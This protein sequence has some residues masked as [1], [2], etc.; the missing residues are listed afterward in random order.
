MPIKAV[1]FDLDGTLLPMDQEAFVDTYFKE[2][3]AHMVPYGYDPKELVQTVWRGTVAMIQNDGS[4]TNEAVFW[5]TFLRQYGE[6]AVADRP[7][8]DEFYRTG[9]AA[10]QRVCGCNPKAAATVDALKQNGVRVVLATSPLF[11]PVATESRI[12]WAGLSP[13]DFE[14]VTT[15]DNCTYCKPNPAYY[16][17]LLTR[18]N[19]EPEDCLMVGNDV[20]DDMVAKTL[21]M[22]VFLLTDHLINKTETDIT[23]FPHGGFD[24]LIGFLRENGL[25]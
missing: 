24:E 7:F 15:Y 17:E 4:A 14:H 9:F 20:G 13:N 10:V 12:R 21:G 11:P 5:Q 18:L 25:I 23:P 22:A 2:L 8:I 3:A 19:L 6:K 16:R 1:L